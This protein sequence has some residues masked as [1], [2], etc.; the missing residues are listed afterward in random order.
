MNYLV[1]NR[2][3]YVLDLY[4]KNKIVMLEVKEDLIKWRVK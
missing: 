1:I 3:K 4:E 2:I